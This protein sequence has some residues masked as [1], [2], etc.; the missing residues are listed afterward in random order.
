MARVWAE[1]TMRAAPKR[2]RRSNSVIISLREQRA[3]G[4]QSADLAQLVRKRL[5]I[6][7]RRH[8]VIMAMN[9]PVTKDFRD[10]EK[11]ERKRQLAGEEGIGKRAELFI[12]A[13][14]RDEGAAPIKRDSAGKVVVADA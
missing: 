14:E 7:R 8:R 4:D 3:T 11:A 10:K 1:M 6:C 12:K 13:A 5:G 9:P 2:V